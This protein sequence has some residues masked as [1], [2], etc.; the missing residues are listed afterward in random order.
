M[1]FSQ[2]KRIIVPEGV[3]AT[4]KFNGKTLWEC[5]KF[6]YVS[7]GDSIAAGHSIY[8]DWESK[9]GER[10][11]YGV[12]GNTETQIV[13]KSYTD[14]IRQD[15]VNTY[16]LDYTSTIS[17]ARS[18]DRVQELISKLDHDVVKKA[19]SKAKYVTVCI[20]ANNVLEPAFSH[21]EEYITAGSLENAEAAIEN[22]FSILSNDNN[23]NS[24]K[25]LF[26]KLVSINP[27]ANYVFTTI[28]NPYKYLHLDEGQNGF[29]STLINGAIS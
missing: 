23:N 25:A 17:F 1:K 5:T 14:L 8:G 15:M 4:I 11:Q 12:N 18:G 26:D 6:P 13:S 2:V 16:G 10:S 24:Y 19:I 7:L 9:Y 3:T 21:L 22:N 20:G 27:N 28:Y 29:F